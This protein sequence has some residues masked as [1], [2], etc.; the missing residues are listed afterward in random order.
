MPNHAAR[1]PVTEHKTY[2]NLMIVFMRLPYA[3]QRMGIMAT[4]RDYIG[5][6]NEKIDIAPANS[7][8]ELQA[9]ETIQHL[10]EEHDL[11]VEL[12]EF[13]APS[14]GKLA[15]SIMSVLLFLGILL[16]GFQGTRLWI[17]G[18]VLVV[19]PTLFLLLKRFGIDLLGGLGPRARS[20]NVIG[21][22]RAEGPLVTKGNR[23]IVI[24]AHYDTP[25]ESFLSSSPA[26]RF[27]PTL[28]RI[29]PVCV[30]I[31]CLMGLLQP[32]PFIPVM[33][34]RILWVVGLILALPPLILGIEGIYMRFSPYTDGAN[35]NKASVA[36]MLGVL[37]K[38][39]PAIDSAEGYG[40][41]VFG[42]PEA[43]E[44]GAY[45]DG[46]ELTNEYEDGFAPDSVPAF[47]TPEPKPEPVRKIVTEVYEEIEGVRHGAEVLSSLRMLPTTCEV[48][49][50]EPQMI[51][52]SE[53]VL[54]R[55]ERPSVDREGI[56]VINGAAE[57]DSR[58][59]RSRAERGPFGRLFARF[60]KDAEEEPDFE[61]ED[62]AETEEGE[63]FFGS[64]INR[65][66]QLRNR[67]LDSDEG[68]FTEEEEVI[69]ADADGFGD[70]EFDDVSIDT[71]D[72]PDEDDDSAE[73]VP[74]E[75]EE[76]EEE[77]PER[78]GFFSRL[79]RL[80]EIFGGA[81]EDEEDIEEDY[82]DQE[83]YD[84]V[85]DEVAGDDEVDEDYEAD[86]GYTAD[87][88]LT[89]PF[90]P[91]IT[92]VPTYRSDDESGVAPVPEAAYDTAL[93]QES[94]VDA[95][96]EQV[97]EAA[98]ESRAASGAAAESLPD[99]ESS[100][101]EVL[102]A[103]SAYES[104]AV[105]SDEPRTS[106]DPDFP[107]PPVYEAE[108]GY[109]PIPALEQM[110][111]S[112]DEFEGE[113]EPDDL[114][115]LGFE[116]VPDPFEEFA[117]AP[118]PD[119]DF[120]PIF[121]EEPAM[122]PVLEQEPEAMEEL[123]PEAEF[124]PVVEE[125]P[126]SESA[127][128][129]E[130]G[131]SPEIE[132]VYEQEPEPA[133]EP[134]VEDVAASGQELAPEDELAIDLAPEAELAIE[135]EPVVAAEPEIEAEAAAEQEPV[136]ELVDFATAEEDAFEAEVA[137]DVTPDQL[138]VDEPEDELIP[139][140]EEIL[141]PTF[142]EAP[143]SETEDE[144]SAEDF[145]P[146]D[147]AVA[148]DEPVD[149]AAP[150]V[151][152][153]TLGA[154][155]PLDGEDDADM[156]AL[157]AT[158]ILDARALAARAAAISAARAAYGKDAEAAV[159]EGI[160][161][162]EQSGIVDAAPDEGEE[163]FEDES[164]SF[165]E[166]DDFVEEEGPESFYNYDDDAVYHELVD[167]PDA[168]FEVIE[169][170]EETEEEGSLDDEG[171]VSD[172]EKTGIIDL[173]AVAEATAGGFASDGEP[174]DEGAV[175]ETADEE[176]LEDDAAEDLGEV[177][178]PEVA[179]APEP[180]PKPE[181]EYVPVFASAIKVSRAMNEEEPPEPEFSYDSVFANA[182]R[183]SRI[184]P[185][186]RVVDD[187]V[188][189]M[190]AAVPAPAPAERS[191]GPLPSASAVEPEV[192]EMAPEDV[193]TEEVAYVPEETAG[194]VAEAI[195]DLGPLTS[196]YETSD[197][198]PALEE[199]GAFDTSEGVE[200]ELHVMADDLEDD[201][202]EETPSDVA[203]S[204]SV[205]AFEAGDTAD[206]SVT[207]DVAVLA[208]ESVADEPIDAPEPETATYEAADAPE[209]PDPA[210]V[211]EPKLT[212]D[213]FADATLPDA[214]YEVLQEE[215][216]VAEEDS[217]PEQGFE[218]GE[219]PEA[220]LLEEAIEADS[221]DT[222]SIRSR[223]SPVTKEDLASRIEIVMPEAE[224]TPEPAIDDLDEPSER[225]A[226]RVINLPEIE[227]LADGTYDESSLMP[228]L[229]FED[230]ADPTEEE[231][232]HRDISGLDATVPTDIDDTAF[233]P[234]MPA[235]KPAAVDEPG[236]GVSDYHPANRNF[237]RRA[238]LFDIPD[239]A[240]SPADPF[241][242]DLGST[243]SNPPSRSSI[244]SRLGRIDD[245]DP[246][247]DG[248][249]DGGARWKGGAAL[250]EG[251]RSED[252]ESLSDEEREEMTEAV[253]SMNDDELIAHDVWFVALGAS[254]LE[255]AGMDE[256]LRAHRKDI[257]GAF[258]VNLDC[259]GAGDLAVMTSEGQEHGRKTDRRIER[260]LTRIADD[261]HIPLS[262]ASHDWGDTDATEAMRQSVRS[263]TIMGLDEGDVPALSQT[264]QDTPA[265]V[266]PAQATQVAEM[267]A[268][269]IRR[270]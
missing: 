270:S 102:A 237:A 105:A 4:T 195:S 244:A 171:F 38:V 77:L 27:I 40:R 140:T 131:D 142:E 82:L 48:I 126:L 173:S 252:G 194:S 187:S 141:E 192:A 11:E 8:E 123:V 60:D 263:I 220:E 211:R 59:R 14:S 111:G 68:D 179:P 181:F 42:S 79:I 128:A 36:A 229:A 216:E 174:D 222:P 116:T 25:R 18:L 155:E 89:A 122:E 207:A 58:P 10:M 101:E 3:Q 144:A 44:G 234:P 180:K 53:R 247:G 91:I 37:S 150:V 163:V 45:D 54:E 146:A 115:D 130:V 260:L 71:S 64:I 156:D 49:Y 12:Q 80:P 228:G 73:F 55:P 51:S 232:S 52:R 103:E 236:W 121:D 114:D 35:D 88:D 127:E 28:R 94:E 112:I 143:A 225:P 56:G 106:Y 135:Q 175:D 162:D 241:G 256:F 248:G 87:T 255:H 117:V 46:V 134:A 69:D 167:M 170:V 120:E 269:L 21:V 62:E 212:Y 83:D 43:G 19:I 250:R 238:A 165:E 41:L 210:M 258:L 15:Y 50:T 235:P 266:D 151:A 253:L 139:E 65:F 240:T 239:P 61:V 7:Q 204:D 188:A 202:L 213:D 183:A 93:V 33:P 185:V 230:E 193:E 254:T 67:S 264:M 208:S 132:L 129:M 81:D 6:L 76:E 182:V 92:A 57:S 104:E 152:E 86:D 186:A 109:E 157:D 70:V 96:F 17:L 5:Y 227:P 219:E 63:G 149:E 217:E 22:H 226:R 133:E 147:D 148:N 119:A 74:D 203:D 215:S 189:Y 85:D 78:R 159:E 66:S 267:V 39:R 177:A 47:L 23:P 191:E 249:T 257:R 176:P 224:E 268:E 233:Q 125:E 154:E 161:A 190:D 31:V 124:E 214:T 24:I 209:E 223:R 262:K 197:L 20:Q 164:D 137:T 84:L 153:E 160:A 99:D 198:A 136:S 145:V 72:T 243:A 13:D 242:T 98:R 166:G 251:L 97:V 110:P 265:S 201:T 95:V 26:A 16:S 118:V 206:L 172:A 259:V 246:L 90:E 231:L 168:D 261:L 169:V 75:E 113:P 199:E 100:Y 138:P 32:L 200:D 245:D 34:R 29:A 2:T 184:T 221:Y 178:A 205:E 218:T 158:G 30:A 108:E 196:D 107:T 9:A 1:V